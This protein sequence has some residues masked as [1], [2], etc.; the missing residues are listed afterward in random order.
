MPE[1]QKT[2]AD[3][4]ERG[5]AILNA[6]GTGAGLGAG[7]TALGVGGHELIKTIRRAVSGRKAR[8]YDNMATGVP[9]PAEKAAM[10]GAE[11][12]NN[13][14]QTIGKVPDQL[15]SVLSA[16]YSNA[17]PGWY[18]DATAKALTV[19]ALG[20]GMYG[21][22]RL[23]NSFAKRKERQDRQD[24]VE[25]AKNRYYA[26]LSGQNKAAATLDA[27][28][29]KVASFGDTA[30]KVLDNLWAPFSGAGK[31]LETGARSAINTQ[32]LLSLAAAGLGGKY[33]Y[34]R[35]AARSRASNVAK[36]QAS[37]T[38]MRGMPNMFV[39]PEQLAQVKRLAAQ[40]PQ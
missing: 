13:V 34:D 18:G 28:Y 23:V 30:A 36:A 1:T 24:E 16:G 27:A 37:R 2:A 12:Y 10:N 6:L 40:Q 3:E 31:A 8:K 22:H 9:V 39:D 20:G 35:T 25:D 4:L 11:L 7:V 14:A 21:G 32:M 17:A 26:I 5:Q 33:M 19:A 15:A 38:R 29:E